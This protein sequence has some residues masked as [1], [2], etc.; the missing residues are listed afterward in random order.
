MKTPMGEVPATGKKVGMQVAHAVH[1]TNNGKTAN[2]EWFYQDMG[3]LMGQLGVSK[4]P[5]RAMVDKPF[6]DNEIVIAKD[7]ANEKRN[8][9]N[10]NKG[11]EAF[12]QRQLEGDERSVRRRPRVVGDR[13]AE[14]R[15]RRADKEKDDD[16]MWKAFPDLALATDTIWAAGDYV[17]QQGTMTGTNQGDWKEMGMK[18]ASRSRFTSCSSTSST[19]T[20]S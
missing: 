13:D 15:E 17:L 19:R 16:A 12:N 7:D 1:F 18:P 20:V 11:I 9:E 6:Q 8:L 2:K 3:E 5:H 10:A 4:A 14:G